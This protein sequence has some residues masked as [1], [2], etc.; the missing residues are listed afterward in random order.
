MFVFA[1]V[2]SSV[3]CIYVIVYIL[4]CVFICVCE[5]VW[6]DGLVGASYEVEFNKDTCR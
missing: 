4:V 5:W 6:V 1:C 3:Q 2:C